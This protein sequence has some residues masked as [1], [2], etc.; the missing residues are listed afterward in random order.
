MEDGA[1]NHVITFKNWNLAAEIP[2]DQFAF[3][4]PE[5][6]ERIPVLE[7]VRLTNKPSPQTQTQKKQ[8]KNN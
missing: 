5:G 7:R 2:A 6:Y 3:K 4:I 1:P 8:S